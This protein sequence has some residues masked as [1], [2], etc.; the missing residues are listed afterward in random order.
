[1]GGDVE[2][3]LGEDVDDEEVDFVFLVGGVFAASAG[4]G[5]VVRVF[6]TELASGFDLDGRAGATVIR[7]VVGGAFFG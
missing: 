6:G 3:L 4:D 2:G 5:Y 1:M 7:Q